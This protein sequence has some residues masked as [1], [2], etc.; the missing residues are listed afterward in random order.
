ME[1][2]TKRRQNVIVITDRRNYTTKIKVREGYSGPEREMTSYLGEEDGCVE[3][4]F[5]V[6][7][8]TT[9]LQPQQEVTH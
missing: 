9:V 5:D 8:P 1:K 6:T 3:H 2:E 4:S 7:Q